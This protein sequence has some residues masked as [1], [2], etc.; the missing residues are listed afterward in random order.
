MTQ[1]FPEGRPPY[2]IAEVGANHNGD[3]G[4]AKK[5][6]DAAKACGCDAAKFQ[7]WD[8]RIF[9]RTVY[10]QNYFLADDYRNRTDYT[11]KEIVEEFTLDEAD[12]EEISEHCRGAGIDF[13][14]TP[15][16]TEQVDALVRCR[17]PFVK[18]AS[19][20]VNNDRLLRHAAA[21]GKP[22]VLSTGMAEMG[23][24]ERAVRILEDASAAEIVVLHCVSVYPAPAEILNLRNIDTLRRAFGHAVGLSDHTLGIGA[25]IA[26]A[27]LGA[28][29]IEKHFT[30]D[31][32][33]FGWDH[34]VST[35]PDEMTL[36]VRAL[37]DAHAALGSPRRE[38]SQRE[39]E[40]RSS[41]RRSL[42]SA[43]RIPAGAVIAVDDIV[44]RRPGTGIDPALAAVVVGMRARRDIDE[45]VVLDW[46]DLEPAQGA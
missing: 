29:V 17:A 43:R 3:V 27:A 37:R 15:F 41:Y 6:V 26:A 44:Y 31:R 35:T 9:S 38:L 5:L 39:R 16:E 10:E 12:F 4:L 13:A 25:P 36:L 20:D 19:M 42:V 23:E 2:V 8:S 45:D 33:M 30:L 18:I 40:T 28:V 7:S 32:D 14:S 21:T 11:L 22:I 46:R 34:K 1:M 24:I